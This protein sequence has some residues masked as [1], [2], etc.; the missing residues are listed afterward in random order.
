MVKVGGYVIFATKLDKNNNNIYESQINSLVEDGYWRYET[1]HQFYR[2][3]KLFG[4]MGKFSSKLVKVLVYQKND[5][6]QWLWL[7][8]NEEEKQ[9]AIEAEK[10]RISD[11]LKA[12]I[13]AKNKTTRKSLLR[14]KLTN[15][16]ITHF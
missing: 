15:D 7:K 2:Y 12:S 6:D 13:A 3:D 9:A 14:K 16:G 11:L 1:Q 10:K 4:D 5:R 8:K